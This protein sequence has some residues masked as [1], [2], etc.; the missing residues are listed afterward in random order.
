MKRDEF[1]RLL[2]QAMDD[3]VV[4]RESVKGATFLIAPTVETMGELAG[5]Y[6]LGHWVENRDRRTRMDFARAP[7]MVAAWHTWAKYWTAKMRPEKALM[8]PFDEIRGAKYRS[9]E[10]KE[11]RAK[12]SPN[13]LP[14]T[15]DI[16]PGD[17]SRG[18][19]ESEVERL[20]LEIV[21]FTGADV[22]SFALAGTSPNPTVQ[23]LVSHDFEP[24][25]YEIHIA[26]DRPGLPHVKEAF[27]AIPMSAAA[28]V[29][30]QTEEV[31]ADAGSLE[32]D[33]VVTMTGHHLAKRTDS[34]VFS[35]PDFRG[36]NMYRMFNQE[37]MSVVPA[38]LMQSHPGLGEVTELGLPRVTVCMTQNSWAEYVAAR[39]HHER[40]GFIPGL[41]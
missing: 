11:L 40:T 18:H 39:E 32:A 14:P 2:N 17:G 41:S 15:L 12:V 37:M 30:Q 38:T 16:D 20:N 5:L 22:A 24:E 1:S 27:K 23:Q 28:S 19:V 25:N 10:A 7:S 6:T 29:Q 8:V 26:F 34:I 35:I 33:W 9:L 4:H 36:V 13:T 31:V 3:L 21:G